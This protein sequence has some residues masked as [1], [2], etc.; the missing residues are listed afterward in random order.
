V[1]TF[2]PGYY[3]FRTSHFTSPG[4]KF[5]ST[6]INP[7]SFDYRHGFPRPTN[8]GFE[9]ADVLSTAYPVLRIVESIGNTPQASSYVPFLRRTKVIVTALVS[10]YSPPSACVVCLLY[11]LFSSIRVGVTPNR[12]LRMAQR[13]NTRLGGQGGLPARLAAGSIQALLEVV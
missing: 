13:G 10:L 12:H 9:K 8:T 7:L 1:S 5:P 2:E 3:L 11:T 4:A 6:A